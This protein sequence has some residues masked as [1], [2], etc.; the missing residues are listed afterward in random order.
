MRR[1]SSHDRGGKLADLVVPERGLLSVK[2]ESIK[3]IIP[4]LPSSRHGSA[5]R[6]RRQIEGLLESRAASSTLEER[7]KCAGYAM[8]ENRRTI[9]VRTRAARFLKAST[10]TAAAAAG[11]SL[12]R[13]APA[14]ADDN[15]DAPRDSGRRWPALCHPGRPRDVVWTRR[16]AN[17][18]VPTCWWRAED[19]RRRAEPKRAARARS[20]ARG[21]IVM[22]V[23]SI[24]TITVRDGAAQLSRQRPS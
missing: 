20:T 10:A 18:P 23:S 2:E 17:S 19:P 4:C 3:D 8:K 21:K 14:A 11:M 22:P 13:H 9:P 1:T 6:S 24:R 15:D 12:I 5:R 16:S 7:K